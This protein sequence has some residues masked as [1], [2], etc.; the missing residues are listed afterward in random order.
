MV[1]FALNI[2]VISEGKLDLKGLASIRWYML[3]MV[4]NHFLRFS[5][6][7]D[8]YFDSEFNEVIGSK[9]KNSESTVKEDKNQNRIYMN[10]DDDEDEEC[11]LNLFRF[12]I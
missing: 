11:T 9:V 8:D 4:C 3:V 10:Y 7:F 2:R 5:I 12:K 6:E 1:Y